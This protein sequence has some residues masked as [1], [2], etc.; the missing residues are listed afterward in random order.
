MIK[1]LIALTCWKKANRKGVFLSNDHVQDF[2][3]SQQGRPVNVKQGA[4]CTMGRVGEDKKP[5]EGEF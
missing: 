5:K 4:I 3:F 2:I 1:E